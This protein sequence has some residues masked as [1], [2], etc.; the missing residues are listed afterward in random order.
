MEI[1]M[2]LPQKI[3]R[4]KRAGGATQLVVHLPCNHEA[5][6]SSPVPH[7]HTKVELPDDPAIPLLGAPKRVI[8]HTI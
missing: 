1:S 2:V 5:L 3:T 8:P 6:S 4:P 7:T